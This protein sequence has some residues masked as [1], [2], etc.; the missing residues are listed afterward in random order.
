[1]DVG[2]ALQVRGNS[3]DNVARGGVDGMILGV[4][5]TRHGR[6]DAIE[7]LFKFLCNHSV[8]EFHHGDCFGWDEEA[9]DVCSHYGIKTVAHPPTK[10]D[11]RAFTQSDVVLPQKA[12]LD[13]NKDIVNSIDFLIA[14][15]DGPERHRSGTWSTV[16]YAKKVGVNGVVWL[17]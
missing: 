13:R 5:G 7:K 1:M 3:A 9:F 6:P 16:R 17:P 11:H 2:C 4:T 10:S 14:A 15:P 8:S 12:Y